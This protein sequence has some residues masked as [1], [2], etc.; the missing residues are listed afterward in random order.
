[1]EIQN[2]DFAKLIG[3]DGDIMALREVTVKVIA[4]YTT[5]VIAGSAKEA[6]ERARNLVF[7]GAISPCETNEIILDVQPIKE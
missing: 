7:I 5:K 4:E 6:Y 2:K 3:N 1:M